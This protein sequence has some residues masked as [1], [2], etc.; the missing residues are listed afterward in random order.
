[1]KITFDDG[2]F[3]EVMSID[4]LDEF[5]LRFVLCGFKNHKE[6]TMSASELSL[7]QIDELMEFL[8]DWRAN[9]PLNHSRKEKEN[10]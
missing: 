9:V 5:K 10:G 3:L 8:S 7:E 1:M 6:L 4:Q 2:S